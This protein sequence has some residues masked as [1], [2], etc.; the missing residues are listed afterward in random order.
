MLSIVTEKLHLVI[1]WI[2]NRKALIFAAVRMIEKMYFISIYFLVVRNVISDDMA[3]LHIWLTL[4]FFKSEIG[5]A[6]IFAWYL[7]GWSNATDQFGRSCGWRSWGLFSRVFGQIGRVS[8]FTSKYFLIYCYVQISSTVE[9]LKI[10]AGG[11]YLALQV[12]PSIQCFHCWYAKALSVLY[13]F[14]MTLNSLI[15]SKYIDFH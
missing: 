7:Q 6:Y 11:R 10:G 8:F 13:Y 1:M 4:T 5:E 9:H 3:W 2:S 12:S 15:F 14:S